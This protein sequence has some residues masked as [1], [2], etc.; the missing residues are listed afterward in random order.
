MRG[1]K[2]G[3]QTPQP[4][5]DEGVAGKRPRTEKND[6]EMDT[7]GGGEAKTSHSQYR[8][9]KGYMTNIYL[10]DSDEEAI[11]DSVKD[12]EEH[13]NKTNKHFKD[14]ARKECLW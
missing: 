14:K 9:K 12:H 8:H 7:E 3:G 11:V 2:P 1:R 6:S 13:Y 10:T 5:T 4:Y